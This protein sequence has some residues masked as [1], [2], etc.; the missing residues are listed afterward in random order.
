MTHINREGRARLRLK[1]A[2]DVGLWAIAGVLAFPLRIPAG[3]IGQA[4][5]VRGVALATVPVALVLVLAFGLQRQV[6]RRV[7]VE[8]LERI[9]AAVAIGT[10]LLFFLGLW[11]HNNDPRFPRAVPLIQGMLALLLLAGMRA[12]IRLVVERRTRRDAVET[13]GGPHH[14]L[15]VGAGSAGTRIGREI[16]RHPEAGMEL[17]G[18]LDDDPAKTRLSIAGRHVLGRLE[19]LPDV[20]AGMGVDEILITM[21]AASGSSTRRVV[22]LARQAGIACR[23]LPGVTQVLSGDAQLAGIRKVEVEDL[24]RREPVELELPV[25]SYV[26]G[27]IVLVTGAGGSIGAELVRQ[28]ARLEPGAVILYDHAE[29]TLYDLQLEL[30]ESLPSLDFR[31]VVGDVRDRIKVDATIGT[32]RPTVVF[33]AAAHKHVPLMEGDPDEAILNNVA[34]TRNI[35][36]AALD[37][38]VSRFVNV[39]TD[40]AVSPASMLGVTKGLAE[41]VVRM[42]GARATGEQT[43]VSVRFGNVLG[44]RG[45]VVPVFQEQIRRG[46]P[47]RVTDP[48]MTRYFMTVPEAARLV[49]QAGALAVNG[50]VYVLDMGTPVRIVDL[51]RDMIHLAGADDGGIRIEFTGL[52]P[53]EKMH[54]ELFTDDEE[55]GSHPHEQIMVVHHEPSLDAG[56]TTCID[57]LIEAAER[58]DWQGIHRHITSLVPSFESNRL[59]TPAIDEPRV[60]WGSS[61]RSSYERAA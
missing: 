24:L 30:R 40:K 35:A 17:V 1:V 46:G 49:I 52:R 12:S 59:W 18:F 44:S 8:D 27:G 28:V 56:F 13:N 29:N 51:A 50:A 47:V 11:W 43:F 21:P 4:D 31:V 42:V 32:Y 5:L 45:S 7:T 26:Q 36:E 16:Q 14:V 58:R 55:L 39:S 61:P 57:E 23:I 38:G 15:L 48:E 41:R 10:G 33:H 6:W 3:W 54:E 60:E 20:G 37:A 53:G 19:D 22:E 34:G 2:L 9:V 25:E